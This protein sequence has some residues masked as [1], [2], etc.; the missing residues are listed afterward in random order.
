MS[1]AL[2]G[3]VQSIGV[4]PEM[5]GQ[6]VG[7]ALMGFAEKRIFARFP[8]V[9][10]H[11]S[12]FNPRAKAFYERLGY[13]FVAEFKEYIIPGHSELLLRKTLGPI[14]DFRPG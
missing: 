14:R 13:E 10:I 5:R 9:F 1:G 4:A 2:V 8:N 6:G 12:S 11:V 7:Q 3:Y